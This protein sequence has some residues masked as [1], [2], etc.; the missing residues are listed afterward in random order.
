MLQIGLMFEGQF[1][2]NWARWRRLLQAAED[3]G[4]QCVFRSDHFTIG[5][6]DDS[7][8]TFTSLTYAADFTKRIELGTCVAPTTF[9]HPSMTARVGAAID[10]L[11]NGR[12]ILGLGAGWNES[13]H[14]EFG[15]PFPDQHTRFDML[16]DALEIT[17][18]LL[19]S[20]QPTSYQGK[21]YSLDG[22]VMLPRPQ[23]KTPIMIGGNGRNRTMPLAANYADEWNAVF[24][25]VDVCRDLNQ[26]MDDL[27]TQAGRAPSSVKRSLMN[28]AFVG[29]SDAELRSK[30][31]ADPR[32][33][34]SLLE[35]KNIVGTPSQI[36]DILG[37]Y[38]DAGVQRV[39]LQWLDLE[40]YAGLELLA[41]DVLP[42]FHR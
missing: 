40:D 11:S 21:V 3:L 35:G 34:E 28:R 30:I 23:R 19:T 12:F 42:H 31:A 20:D 8:E 27:L 22:A 33:D 25:T 26:H 4:F 14:R 29:A 6:A 24:V 38:Q 2:L 36:V 1:G 18:R 17:Q 41:R 7:L 9:R 15:V 16:T 13:E 37:R 32:A 39:M 5:V 10:D